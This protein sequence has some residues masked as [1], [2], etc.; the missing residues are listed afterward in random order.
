MSVSIVYILQKKWLVII[1]INI[2]MFDFLFRFLHRYL[3]R[4]SR[5]S[6]TRGRRLV[7][8]L[9]SLPFVI[10][11]SFGIVL[12]GKSHTGLSL[13]TEEEYSLL[14]RKQSPSLLLPV[15]SRRA[16]PWTEPY[17]SSK[18]NRSTSAS[19][20]SSRLRSSSRRRS[21]SWLSLIASS[22]FGSR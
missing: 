14:Y 3:V 17:L 11:S 1:N 21:S 18:L 13:T 6:H 12:C 8:H 2:T 19:I 16:L 9:F 20:S 22:R 5:I 10:L 7:L 4:Y 15:E